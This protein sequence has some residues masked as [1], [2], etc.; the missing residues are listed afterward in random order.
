[1]ERHQINNEDHDRQALEACAASHE[2]FLHELGAFMGMLKEDAEAKDLDHTDV[3]RLIDEAAK[4]LGPNTRLDQHV[5]C[6]QE[7]I[8]NLAEAGRSHRI[9]W[10][11]RGLQTAY[12]GAKRHRDYLRGE[13]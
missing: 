5:Q 1:M 11:R 8:R 4:I 3:F 9:A 6:T 2:Q 7:L 13:L 12:N 10:V